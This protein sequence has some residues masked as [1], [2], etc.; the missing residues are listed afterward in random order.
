VPDSSAIDQALVDKLLADAT[1]TA[2]MPGGVHVDEAT[3]GLMQFVIV[4][5]ADEQD[6]PIFEGRGAEDALYLVEARESSQVVG[7]KNIKG[8]A[9]RIDAL[10]ELGTLTIAGYSLLVIRRVGRVRLTE[11]D[12]VDTSI[13]WQRRGGR[14]QVMTAPI[15]T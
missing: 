10:L 4:S 8:A 5:L 9:A 12:A 3:A 11:V 14:Y 15:L 7:T 2:L 1:L 13:R 6:T